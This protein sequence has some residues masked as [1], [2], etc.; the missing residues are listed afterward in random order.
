MLTNEVV[1]SPQSRVTDWGT[2]KAS[3]DVGNSP[4][5]A[6]TEEATGLYTDFWALLADTGYEAW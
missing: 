5:Q 2:V 4:A 3:G 6:A 1:E